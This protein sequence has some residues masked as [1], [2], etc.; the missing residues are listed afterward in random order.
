M[1]KHVLLFLAILTL[2][3][4]QAIAQVNPPCPTPPPPGSQN[5][6]QACVYCDFD[7]YMGTNNGFPSGGNTICG[8][9][10]IH[11]DEWFGFTA[12]SSSITIT[13]LTSNCLNGDGLQSAFFDDC[14][15]DDALVCN[16][17]SGGGAGSPLTLTYDGFTIGETY[18]FMLDG[19]SA[20]V[21]DFEIEITDGSI[22]PGPPGLATQPQGPTV[23][24]PGA[25]AV[26]TVN[27]VFAAGS[28]I[29]TAPAGSSINGLGSVLNV[30]APEGNTVTITFGNSGGNVCV[31]ADNACN[32]PTAANCLPV[33]NQPIP[34]TVR[35]AL[36]ICAEDAPFQWDEDPFPLLTA[37][38]V[39]TLTSTPYDSYLGCDSLVLQSVTIKQIA[40]TPIGTRYICAG[41][42]FMLA[43]DSYCDPGNYN[44]LFESFQGCD[45][46]VSFSLVVL[47]PLAN[48]PPP[49]NPI[50]CNS[51]GVVL[52][53]TGSTPLG[54]ASYAWTNAA[55][56]V[57]GGIGTYNATLTGTYN[58]IVTVQA[59]G[60][61]CRD[62]ASVVVTGN[63][64]APGATATGANINCV[65]PTAVL[66]GSS[67][68]GGV[69]YTWTGPGISPANQFQQNP[70]V[71]Q[72]GVYVLTVRNP[73][74]GCTSIATVS[75]A[76]DITP[77]TLSAVG[78]T[79]T[80]TS[81]SVTIN[82][83]TNASPAMF[84]WTGPGIN[85]GN[86][87]LEDPAVL[88][89]GNY[90][91]TVTNTTNGCTNT[92]TAV[93]T[94]NTAIP[95]AT[96][97]PDAILT[98]TTPNT[99][100][101]GVGNG[102]GQPITFTWTGPNNF[103]S[104]VPQPNVNVVGTYILTVL[105]T[106]NGCLRRDTVVIA[107]N[108]AIPNASAGADS[109]ITCVEPSVVLIGTGSSN[110][111]NF[112]PTW[113]GPGINAGNSNVLSPEVDQQ[114]TYTL[115]I[116]NNI[117]GCTATDTVL[118]D[119]NTNLPTA[120]A[121]ID[122]T[123]T[124]TTPSGVTLNG[125]G[126]PG[127][128]TYFWSGPGIGA[129]NDNIPNPTVTQPG[130]YN[131]VVTDPA[132]GCTAT[133]QATVIQDA[134]VPEAEG[135]ADLLLNCTINTVDINGS[136][137]SVGPDIVYAWTG[138]G[139]SGPNATAQS[140][141]G[142]TLPGTYNLAVTNTSNSCV[143][144]D[145][146]VITQ[147]IT[148]PTVNAG[149]PVVLNCANSTMDTLFSTGS[150]S[151]ANFVRLWAG[152][153]I[154]P[155]NQ[156]SANP[157]INNAPDTYTLTITNLTNTCTATDQVVVTL[158]IAPPTAD[159][160]SDNVID[161]IVTSV[162]IGGNSSSGANFSYLWTGPG[163]TAVNESQG[164]PA[165]S[166]PG[167]YN[168]VVTDSSN[169]CTATDAVV[170][171]TNAVFPTTL[172]GNDGLLTCVNTTALLDGSA[173]SNGP[174][175]QVQWAGPD[176]NAGNENQAAPTVS[177][178]GTYILE[179][180]N[181]TNSCVTRD[182]VV[183]D[184]NIATPAANAGQDRILNCQN[185][186]LSLNGSLSDV[187]ATI[188]YLWTGPSINPSTEGDVNPPIDQPGTY[189][190]LLTDTDNGCTSSDQVVVTQNNAVPTASAGANGLINCADLTQVLDGSGSS[191]GA[192][193]T[194]V[195]EGPDINSNN[196]DNQ[197]P[198][199][200]LSGTYM[201]TVT[202]TQNFCTATDVVF[203]A[204]DKTP[205]LIVAGPDGLLTCAV[206]STLL[207]ATQ[208]ASGL[209]IQFAW[210]G[211]G[212]VSGGNTPTPTINL[213][214][215][216]VLT[217]T[218]TNNG[219]TNVDAVDVTQ[220]II[221]PDVSA[222]S[223]LIINCSNASMGVI[224]SSVGSSTGSEY[225]YL[226][227]GPGISAANENQPNPTVFVP[228][229]YTLAIT[230]STNGCS[231]TDD[232]TVSASQELPTA[233]AG[234]DQTIDCAN[235]DAILDGTGSTTLNGSLEFLWSGPGINMGNETGDMPTVTASGLYTLVVTNSLTGCQGTDEVTVLLD[236]QPPIATAT[237]DLI[238]CADPVSTIAATSS[239][240]NATYF[241][242]GQAINPNNSGD[243]SVEVSVAGV[244]SVTVTAPNGCTGTATTVVALDADVP[245]GAAEGTTL[246]CLN[247][248]S[249]VISGQ[250]VSPAGSTFNWTGPGIGTVTTQ[251][252]TVTQP[253][254]YTFTIFAPNGC[255]RPI[256]V[257]VLANFNQ[258]TVVAVAAETIDC[259][260]SEVTIN[261]TGTAVGPNFSYVWTTQNGS[262]VSGAN[263]LNPLVDRAG[264][265]RLVVTNST[266]GCTNSITV[267][268]LIDP[269]VPTGFNVDVRNIQC[270][271]DQNGSI[272][273]NGIQGGTAPFIFTLSGNTGSANNQ[274]TGLTAGEYVLMLE[275]A[276]GCNLDTT[277]TIGEPGQLQV[278]LG[279]DIVVSLGEEATVTAQLFTTV[280]LN[281]IQWNYSP[282]CD[283][284][285]TDCETFTY[286]P[287]ESYR[288]TITVTDLNGC[289][290]RDQILVIVEKNRQIYVPNIFNPDSDLNYYLGV[291]TGIDVTKVKTFS[292]FDRWGE[293]VFFRDD[294][295]PENDNQ[296]QA[297]DGRYR[298]DK[299]QV[300]VYVWL[301]EVEFIDGETK[302]FK[303]DV[304]LIR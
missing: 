276:N 281:N 83:Q 209:N 25:T 91:V 81:A 55:W 214:G 260:T 223:N 195:W 113:S 289:V 30:D 103:M 22:T 38:G 200:A 181:T 173:S 49:A 297:W 158:D 180:T 279:P 132:N 141:T 46:T 95:T 274:Y 234:P 215:V 208:S 270:F 27:D 13:L 99:N 240:P 295:L 47:N 114:G 102:N 26:Y 166:Q 65:S 37:P 207:D 227:T 161:C 229:T 254:T 100:L 217:L 130:T 3:C 118:V 31:Q 249:S 266:N 7:G 8:Q 134:D 4:G 58:L 286:Q 174:N 89:G 86:Q 154:T 288:H 171:N 2:L 253:G 77:P 243:Q 104:N 131:L 282:G 185:T 164:A 61:Q 193:F 182:T 184:Q 150:S 59:G 41:E 251:S 165:I 192:L 36:V 231:D 34:I 247:G 43:G 17:G 300:G 189:I 163:I 232:V 66:M 135:G 63:T 290:E 56:N 301:C 117:N 287:Y 24:C 159:A 60:V 97:G 285:S 188:V 71:G 70:T 292:I 204:L 127:N 98:C 137:S 302:L 156:N 149:N 74:N 151:G 133:D 228:G 128:V 224:L 198:T 299:A 183:V 6:Q 157:I 1:Q 187:G 139:I 153:G 54:Q 145:V 197:S 248:G 237:A 278:E 160:G 12:G 73:V 88:I 143:N 10:A 87:T 94:T 303:G 64:V 18:F 90:A 255:V 106:Q 176:I 126:V 107:A 85:A 21:C 216:Y 122:N 162:N 40:P 68:T 72:P 124:C 199:V 280:G 167:T 69:N 194:Y 261:A 211:P 257:A 136:G 210:T 112:T 44:V 233:D 169:G 206:T 277:I 256:D 219:C 284:L 75:V 177:L 48:I 125:S 119:I 111:P 96:A 80:C 226:W 14:S 271:G 268:V 45:S 241:W 32:P 93:V 212:I 172:A 105:N 201:V 146:V 35:P 78:D 109:L 152:P 190:L 148:P 168:L 23:V 259:N 138:P 82:G 53:S 273:V 191:M 296:L 264:A 101:Q 108:Q 202:N 272:T 238:T 33:T 19:W 275:D 230:N 175:F 11:N 121:G 245:Q 51:S 29:W 57:L 221:T 196:F 213:S 5:C 155:A 218:N 123:L 236:N 9:I 269:L 120:D 239:L 79:I 42:C 265:Y 147:N 267:P 39:F 225:G 205:P 140:P 15:D 115:L 283:T 246:N 252:V 144:T 62:T 258:P 50:D 291:Y 110:G 298:G 116:T 52:T 293:Q 28:Y 250:I 129:N 20:D 203:V 170:V 84:F 76:G 220:D 178:P 263:T 304:T 235:T 142:I 186:S 294:Y 16:P 67:P 244:Y 262:I 92:A 222:G 242:Q 179:I